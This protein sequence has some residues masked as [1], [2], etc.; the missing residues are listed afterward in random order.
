MSEFRKLAQQKMCKYWETATELGSVVSRSLIMLQKKH[1]GI[2]WVRSDLV[3]SQEASMEIFNLRKQVEKLELKLEEARTQA[4]PGTD[5]LA[6]GSEKFEIN[7]KC[8]SKKGYKYYDW[9]D[10]MIKTWDEIFYQVSPIMINEAS[11]YHIKNILNDFI[12][13]SC[14]EELTNS[15][16]GHT[17]GHFEIKN[18]DFQTIKVQLR[19]LGL[20]CKSVKNRSVKDT[21]TYWTLTPYGDSVMNKLRAIKKSI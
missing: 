21:M 8:T 19:A 2:G 18:E 6:Q 4:P 11:D 1:P 14:S 17:F 9:E 13:S 16:E 12:E 3:S 10:S 7:Y 15:E 20:I 5:N